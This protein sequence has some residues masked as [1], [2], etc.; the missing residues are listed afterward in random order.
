M[1]PTDRTMAA[2]AEVAFVDVAA[3]ERHRLMDATGAIR[4]QLQRNRDIRDLWM[5]DQLLT[6]PIQAANTL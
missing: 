1:Q 5:K 6:G 3:G 2:R 4:H